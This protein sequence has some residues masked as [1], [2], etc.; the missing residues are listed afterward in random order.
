MSDLAT[1]EIDAATRMLI[2]QLQ[3]DDAKQLATHTEYT[4]AVQEEEENV[5]FFSIVP[6][7]PV[8]LNSGLLKCTQ[9]CLP[10][11]ELASV[12]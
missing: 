9:H 8:H 10:Q 6:V 11:L 12:V 5:S 7:R 3:M 4:E 1:Q 2:E